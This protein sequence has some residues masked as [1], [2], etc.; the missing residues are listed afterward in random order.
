MPALAGAIDDHTTTSQVWT[1][2]ALQEFVPNQGDAWQYLLTGLQAFL[3]KVDA[4]PAS[5][6]QPLDPFVADAQRLGTRTAEMHLALADAAND[7]AFAP[8]PLSGDEQRRF[9]ERTRNSWPKPSPCCAG[10]SRESRPK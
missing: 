5:D 7:A 8:E 4:P 10:K 9:A 1:L 2:A 3:G 6:Q